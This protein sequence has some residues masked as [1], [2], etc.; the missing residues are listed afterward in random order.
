MSVISNAMTVCYL[1]DV[2]GRVFKFEGFIDGM[3]F[4][5]GVYVLAF[6]ATCAMAV[7]RYLP[8]V[9]ETKFAVT[10][11]SLRSVLTRITEVIVVSASIA[12][13]GILFGA[14]AKAILG[15][16]SV[17]G[18][19]VGRGIARRRFGQSV[20]TSE[21]TARASVGKHVGELGDGG[22]SLDAQHLGRVVGVVPRD[23]HDAVLD[24]HA[25][26]FRRIWISQGDLGL[27]FRRLLRLEDAA[28]GF[29]LRRPGRHEN[30]ERRRLDVA[31]T[32][33]RLARGVFFTHGD[34]AS[35]FLNLRRRGGPVTERGFR[36]FVAGFVVEKGPRH[37]LQLA[38][39]RVD[40]VDV[41]LPRLVL[42]HVVVQR[43]APLQLREL[44]LL[45]LQKTLTPL[46]I[47]AKPLT[48]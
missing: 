48:G 36:L 33:R 1:N 10:S 37:G 29:G 45:P 32:P 31:G 7:G 20:R 27:E 22:A 44:L 14:S 24:V 8:R 34:G 28:P 25:R 35:T 41:L 23:H 38:N 18:L 42:D 16:G 17:G 13:A 3:G 43:L 2:L 46:S 39:A 40:V 26:V 9:L 5:L 6:G 21:V 47:S 11:V 12:Q 4:D 19:A 15:V 30:A